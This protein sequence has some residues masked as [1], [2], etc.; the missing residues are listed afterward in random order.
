MKGIITNVGDTQ[1]SRNG[2]QYFYVFFKM[3]DGQSARTHLVPGYRNMAK[4]RPVLEAYR[5]HPEN[6][7]EVTGLTLRGRTVDADSDLDY[8]VI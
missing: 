4:W 8:T 6:Q 3:E 2:G 5:T 7:I 1:Q